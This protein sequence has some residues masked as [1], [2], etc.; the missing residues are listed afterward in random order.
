[1]AFSFLAESKNKHTMNIIFWNKEDHTTAELM[2][3]CHFWLSRYKSKS[4]IFIQ[5]SM[6]VYEKWIDLA[7]LKTLIHLNAFLSFFPFFFFLIW[8]DLCEKSETKETMIFINNINRKI[9]LRI[10][11]IV[12]KS[13][14]ALLEILWHEKGS[15]K[16]AK[17]A[18]RVRVGDER[19]IWQN[20]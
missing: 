5:S 4:Q 14:S 8:I 16:A 20:D 11:N 1:M 17:R 7:L 6:S 3:Y 19:P 9:N 12:S 2:K 13:H 15:G 10:V 18:D